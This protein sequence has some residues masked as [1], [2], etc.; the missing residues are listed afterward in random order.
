MTRDFSTDRFTGCSG[1]GRSYDEY[2]DDEYDEYDDDDD[3]DWVSSFS[4]S[5]VTFSFSFS[6]SSSLSLYPGIRSQLISHSSSSGQ[7]G[8]EFS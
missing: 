7:S 8:S 1:G 6:S 2:D 4:S 3:D 5:T